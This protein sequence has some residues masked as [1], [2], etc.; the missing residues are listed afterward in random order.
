MTRKLAI[1]QASNVVAVKDQV[2]SD[3]EGESVILHLKSGTYYGL[4]DVGA[5]IWNL[6]QE[7][8]KVSELREAILE[9]YEV[10]PEQCEREILELLQQLAAKELIEVKN[11]AVV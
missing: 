8:K 7:P 1:S 4:N 11:E 10:E 5:S 2:S 6:I 9:E 3:L